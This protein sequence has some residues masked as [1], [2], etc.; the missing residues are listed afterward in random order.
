MASLAEQPRFEEWAP[1][2]AGVQGRDEDVDDV[3]RYVN[4]L[5]DLCIELELPD[6]TAAMQESSTAGQI[7]ALKSELMKAGFSQSELDPETVGQALESY[8]T[9]SDLEPA[10]ESGG[11]YL[12]AH[13]PARYDVSP[14]DEVF[15]DEAEDEEEE[16]RRGAG[17]EAEP[18][19]DY[20]P[21]DEGGSTDE[22]I[23]GPS[24]EEGAEEQGEEEHLARALRKHRIDDEAPEMSSSESDND[25]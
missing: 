9:R 17:D 6:W 20:N 18:D 11:H 19:A 1:D 21:E 3:Q 22:V 13:S 12:R 7:S 15:G 24:D 16:S 8:Q 5:A 25:E 4:Q 14:L 23:I 2:P 10:R